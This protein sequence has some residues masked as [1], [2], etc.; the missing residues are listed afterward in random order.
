M[1]YRNKSRGL[2]LHVLGEMFVLAS[3]TQEHSKRWD[4]NMYVV[5][6]SHLGNYLNWVESVHANNHTRFRQ[7][8]RTPFQNKMSQLCLFPPLLQLERCRCWRVRAVLDLTLQYRGWLRCCVVSKADKK[9]RTTL[10]NSWQCFVLKS[11]VYLVTLSTWKKPFALEMTCLC[12]ISLQIQCY[13]Y[14][15]V[16][17]RS[18]YF[19]EKYMVTYIE[20]TGNSLM[21]VD[22]TFLVFWLM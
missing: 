1:N 17:Y 3:L 6:E 7:G 14:W 15:H 10:C 20:A 16:R 11:A 2:V 4:Y 8:F 19:A 12:K 5:S 9:F 21:D 18:L 13:K 22:D